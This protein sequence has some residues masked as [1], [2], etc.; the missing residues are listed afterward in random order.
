MQKLKVA[1]EKTGNHKKW[2]VG[3][4]KAVTTEDNDSLEPDFTAFHGKHNLKFSW[5]SLF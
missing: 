4:Y 1:V 3:N 2:N 5:H